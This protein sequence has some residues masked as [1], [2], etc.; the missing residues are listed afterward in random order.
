MEQWSRAER[1]REGEEEG[2]G[3]GGEN[4]EHLPP[5][6]FCHSNSLSLSLRFSSSVFRAC[7]LKA[8]EGLL[9]CSSLYFSLSHTSI[10]HTLLLSF[11]SCRLMFSLSLK[12]QLKDESLE[13]LRYILAVSYPQTMYLS[14]D[15]YIHLLPYHQSE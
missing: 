4:K 12:T 2:R 10:L 15:R 9:N 7:Y 14:A 6:F 13:R 5:S 8:S 11:L 1:R 3:Q